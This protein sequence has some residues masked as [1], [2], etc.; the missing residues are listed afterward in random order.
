V[1]PD[2][3]LSLGREAGTV[4]LLI[5]GPLLGAGLAVGIA[6]SV[7]QAVTQIQEASLS[8]IPK[9]AAMALVTAL[10]GHWM[11]GQLVGYTVRLFTNLNAFAQ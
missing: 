2:A 11:L 6:V 3:V 4:A 8:F 5:A 9:V 7:F 10:L 1:T